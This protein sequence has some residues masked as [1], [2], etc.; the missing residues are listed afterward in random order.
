[1]IQVPGVDGAP[2]LVFRAWT[3]ADILQASS[4]LPSIHNGTAFAKDFLIFCKEFMPTGPEVHRLLVKHVGPTDFSKI[5]TVVTGNGCDSRL[6]KLD[7]GDNTNGPYRTF[8]E[9]VCPEI[10]LRFPSK[11]NMALINSTRQGKTEDVTSYHQRLMSAFQTHS[12]LEEPG[13][14]TIMTVWETH[15]KNAFVNGL[16]PDIKAATE[17]S[18]IGLEDAR[19]DEVGGPRH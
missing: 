2:G 3:Q 15:L 14:K 18:V 10:A 1:M 13:D 17:R 8:I 7:W 11:V 9:A 16:L 12:G 19:L 6:I 5:R 4:H